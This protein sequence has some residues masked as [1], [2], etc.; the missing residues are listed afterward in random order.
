MGT[1]IKI[2]PG[3]LSN[4]ALQFRRS[5][6][7]SSTDHTNLLQ[8][9]KVHRL[10]QEGEKNMYVMAAD[11]MDLET[12]KTVPQLHM[13][14]LW[15]DGNTL[16]G[17][18]V[19]NRV[20]GSPSD[21]CRPLVEAALKDAGNEPRALSTVHGLSEWVAEGIANKKTIA[22]LSSLSIGEI[23]AIKRLTERI[24]VDDDTYNTAK[25]GIE[26]LAKE[27]LAEGLGEEAS[28]YQSKGGGFVSIDHHADKTDYSDTSFGTMAVFKF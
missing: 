1:L 23:E 25:K 19:V 7:A 21:V 14:R 8:G 13:A 26:M 5:F 6:F 24:S 12:V 10:D 22:T 15:R 17:V 4:H 27:F 11:G 28:L 9:A 2:R 18:K 20:L 3:C 16:Y